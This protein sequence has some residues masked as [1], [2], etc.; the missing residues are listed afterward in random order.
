MIDAQ[1]RWCIVRCVRDANVRGMQ[2]QLS[3]AKART[4]VERPC[5][6]SLMAEVA[7]VHLCCSATRP[8]LQFADPLAPYCTS[9]VVHFHR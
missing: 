8:N 3:G 7:S 5:V 4:D 1:G 6:L 2:P 9:A